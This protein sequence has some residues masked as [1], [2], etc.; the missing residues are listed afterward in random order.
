MLQHRDVLHTFYVIDASSVKQQVR[1]GKQVACS[2]YAAIVYCLFMRMLPYISS[3][4]DWICSTVLYGF[5]HVGIKLARMHSMW[6]LSCK[7]V[8][9]FAITLSQFRV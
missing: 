2:M 1:H 4:F 8:S 9:V 5:L 3:S 7:C 6:E